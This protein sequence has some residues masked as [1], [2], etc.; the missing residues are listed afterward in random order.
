[1]Q[2]TLELDL[3]GIFRREMSLEEAGGKVFEEVIATASGRL[4]KSELLKEDLTGF[5]ITRVGPSL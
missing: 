5:A 2:D 3:S 4:T 1:M